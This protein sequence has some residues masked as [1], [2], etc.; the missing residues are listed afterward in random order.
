MRTISYFSLVLAYRAQELIPATVS[1]QQITER[2]YGVENV[3]TFLMV[4]MGLMIF[5]Y[6]CT[7]KFG[8]HFNL[9]LWIIGILLGAFYDKLGF[10]SSSLDYI[11][12]I[13]LGM[14]III[15]SPTLG[16]GSNFLSNNYIFFGRKWQLIAL[17]VG[18]VFLSTVLIGVGIKYLTPLGYRITLIEAFIIGACLC[19]VEPGAFMSRLNA[20]GIPKR[21][22][23]LIHGE[24]VLTPGFSIGVF[25][26]FQSI[27]ISSGYNFGET[28]G[29]FVK[30]TIAPVFICA[31]IGVIF[32]PLMIMARRSLIAIL[33]TF[34]STSFIIF[35]CVT[36]FVNLKIS[37]FLGMCIY[38]QTIGY[39]TKEYLTPDIQRSLQ[40]VWDLI[41]LIADGT[42]VL[43][44][45]GFVGSLYWKDIG[46]YF[47]ENFFWQTFLAFLIVLCSRTIK[48]VALAPILNLLGERLYWKDLALLSAI[49]INGT[50]SICLIKE[51]SMRDNPKASPEY[52]SIFVGLVSFVVVLQVLFVS[53]VNYLGL[54]KYPLFRLQYREY[55]AIKDRLELLGDI[56]LHLKSRLQAQKANGHMYI[57]LNSVLDL[58]RDMFRLIKEVYFI[59]HHYRLEKFN[60]NWIF[61]KKFT[62]SFLIPKIE[63]GLKHSLYLSSIK[64]VAGGNETNKLNG[65]DRPIVID[66]D[67]DNFG[68]IPTTNELITLRT[69]KTQNN[70]HNL[71]D[72]PIIRIWP[73]EEKN[74][75]G[76][77]LLG[78][79]QVVSST[80]VILDLNSNKLS[81]DSNS[82]RNSIYN[83]RELSA[84]RDHSTSQIQNVS[85]GN[86]INDASAFVKVPDPNQLEVSKSQQNHGSILEDSRPSSIHNLEYP[87]VK[88]LT[89]F[90]IDHAVKSATQGFEVDIRFQAYSL[91]KQNLRMTFEQCQCHLRT[92]NYGSLLI[93]MSL[94]YFHLQIRFVKTHMKLFPT[95]IRKALQKLD[96]YKWLQPLVHP[97]VF[98]NNYLEYEVL[99]CLQTII[100][101]IVANTSQHFHIF[102]L[103][104]KNFV[105]AELTDALEEIAHFIASSH[106]SQSIDVLRKCKEVMNQSIYKLKNWNSS[107][108]A[109]GYIT[110]DELVESSREL[111]SKESRLFHYFALIDRGNTFKP[112]PE[113]HYS[114]SR[115]ASYLLYNF[116]FLFELKPMTLQAFIQSCKF[117][118]LGKGNHTDFFI[119]TSDK[120]HLIQTGK[121]IFNEVKAKQ[122]N[123][124]NNFNPILFNI[125]ACLQLGLEFQ[126]LVAQQTMLVAVDF[127]LIW[128]IIEESPYFMNSFFFTLAE[129]FLMAKYEPV[130]DKVGLFVQA[131][132]AAFADVPLSHHLKL[133]GIEKLE[134]QTQQPQLIKKPSMY[135]QVKLSISCILKSI[136][137]DSIDNLPNHPLQL[138]TLFTLTDHSI[139]IRLVLDFNNDKPYS[140]VIKK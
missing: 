39:M 43:I 82:H 4:A 139:T 89:E 86:A 63:T 75:S 114:L 11:N 1:N 111:E 15:Y 90:Y 60:K 37:S 100:E 123:A 80:S 106:F 24:S 48:I 36:S 21:I 95:F 109:K 97:T 14:L 30:Y 83:D 78:N 120:I 65:G 113:I 27:Q 47:F 121:L 68:V 102:S 52:R 70:L 118:I 62:K 13:T 17:T 105:R 117:V 132:R 85:I 23:S 5:A 51:V 112:K 42:L 76:F 110:E 22:F 12:N 107:A 16:F 131:L 94:D 33:I 87:K 135:F 64:P 34:F 45:G 134:Q 127:K 125:F 72:V 61:H 2:N 101:Q 88:K 58:K 8:V 116:P 35:L 54:I 130:N 6:Y 50:I 32:S 56:S 57:G 128:Q 59:R 69:Q 104:Q 91:V 81:E 124:T 119:S 25:L 55:I 31:G 10:M 67:P 140:N 108:F 99:T 96:Q 122:P 41:K 7:V 29:N 71:Q 49:G 129:Q 79:N 26:L 77:E 137:K 126:V 44:A 3:I 28:F 136:L 40:A 53:I 73:D 19:C 115:T 84:R 103:K 74:Q 92:L 38:G 98:T 18:G 133:E 46:R 9:P 138:V 93:D 66:H 20:L